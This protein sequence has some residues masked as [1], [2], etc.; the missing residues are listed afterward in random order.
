MKKNTFLFLLFALFFAACDSVKELPEGAKE[1]LI[2]PLRIVGGVELNYLL[3]YVSTWREADSITS[4][5]LEVEANSGNWSEFKVSAPDSLYVATLKIWRGGRDTSVVVL[6]GERDKDLLIYS[7]GCDSDVI[8]IYTS[9]SSMDLLAMWQNEQISDLDVNR[10][11]NGV[12]NIKIPSAAKEC[13]RSWIRVFGAN[14]KGRSNDLLIPLE[15][16]KPI[17][18]VSLLNRFD[19]HKQV[20]YSVFVDRFYNG[21][22][23]NDEPLNDPEVMPEVDF[24]GGDIKGITKKIK[25]GFFKDLGINTIIITPISENPRGAWSFIPT[26]A[27]R[28]SGYH[29]Y[30]PLYMTRVDDRFGTEEE[31]KELLDIAHKNDMNVILDYVAHHLHIDS[32]TL[33]ENPDWI[34]DFILPDGRENLRLWDE[35]RLTTWFDRHIPTLDL[36]REEV[37]DAMTD[38]ALFWVANYDFDGFRHDACKQIPES[39]WRMLTSKIK[40]QH[41]DKNFWQ[42]GETYGSHQLVSSY[43]KS[44]MIDA[45]FDFNVFESALNVFAQRYSMQFLI[46]NLNA[47][48][49]EFGSHHTMGMVTGNHD[50]IRFTTVADGMVPSLE[51]NV[52]QGWVFEDEVKDTISYDRLALMYAFIST[53]PGVPCIFQG[54]EHGKPGGDDPDNRRMMQFESYNSKE[55]ELKDKVKKLL[56]LRQNS[57]SLLY[58][59]LITLYSD[60]FTWVYARIYMGE[61]VVVGMNTYGSDKEISVK[62]PKGLE[63]N[64]TAKGSFGSNFKLDKEGRE[65]TLSLPKNG[66]NIIE[67]N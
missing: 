32:P 56:Y 34:T 61:L 51:G 35:H 67:I 53:V 14:S 55:V 64:G 22:T 59:D 13:K 29:G 4:E 33:K 18:D 40:D 2:L 10:G 48:D 11:I 21:V 1:Q 37:R 7:T 49:A 47:S 36:D 15:Y 20:M 26:P 12:V 28:F 45:Q 41:P 54:D 43:I 52:L 3:D 50:K 57:M 58:G 38:S 66:F 42:I 8:D 9:E 46:N 65:L 19:R 5:H 25:E 60:H 16:G 17:E 30:W 27:T 63:I 31:L 62:L 44:G 39:Y 24:Q 23:E 6:N